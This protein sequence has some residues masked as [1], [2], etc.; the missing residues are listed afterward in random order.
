[1]H[2]RERTR[3]R[4]N[5]HVAR[6]GRCFDDGLLQPERLLVRVNFVFNWFRPHIGNAWLGFPGDE[7]FR[8][9]DMRRF[10]EEHCVL[11]SSPGGLAA[12]DLAFVPCHQIDELQF[13]LKEPGRDPLA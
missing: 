3:D 1:M 13:I 11:A 10:L 8:A 9:D 5:H 12:A 7:P 2:D 4:I 6:V